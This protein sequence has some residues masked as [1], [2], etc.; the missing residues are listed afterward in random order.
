GGSRGIWLIA[1]GSPSK[2][3]KSSV[4]RGGTDDAWLRGGLPGGFEGGGWDMRGSASARSG[5]RP[6][7]SVNEIGVG[8]WSKVEQD[9]IHAVV[10]R[11]ADQLGADREDHLTQALRSGRHA[12][13]TDLL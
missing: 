2:S 10:G 8:S 6:A 4:I 11:D 9:R 13:V 7:A 12:D 1:V 3:A 5:N